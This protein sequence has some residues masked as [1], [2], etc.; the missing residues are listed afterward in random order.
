MSLVDANIVL[1]YLLNDQQEL[2][3]KAFEI[4]KNNKSVVLTE[5]LCEIVYVLQKVYNVP[6]K[7]IQT[8]LSDLINESVIIVEQQDIIIQ[9]LLIY[10]KI[11]IDIVDAIL[12]A[13]HVVDGKKIFTLDDKLN[14]CLNSQKII[15]K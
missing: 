13:Y 15:E 9:A 1:R 7:E 8:N 3:A 12:W 4:I 2:S 6:K 11:S 14:R 10:S 5:V